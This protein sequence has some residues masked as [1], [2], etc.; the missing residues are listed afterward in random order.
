MKK[1]NLKA[2]GLI[3]VSS[4]LF[5]AGCNLLKD[6][7]YKVD[8]N[9]LEMHG[10]SI[11][12]VINGKFVEKGLHK[13]AVV[14][15]TPTLY[16]ADGSK[17]AFDTKTFKGEKAAGNGEVVTKGGK[18]FTYRSTIPYTPELEVADLKVELLPKKGTKEK[19]LVVTDKIADATIITPLL[20]QKDARVIVGADKF[21]RTTEEEFKAVIHYEKNKSVVRASELKD[22]DIKALED[23]LK[24][25][26]GNQR[27][28]LK[29][30]N[31]L[32]YA[33]P[34]G[35]L[36]LNT[37]LAN[38]RAE[39]AA[40]YLLG[41]MKR[42]KLQQGND[43]IK[44]IP[45]GEDWDGFK[46]EVEKTT[47]PDKDII[48]RVLQMTAD[49]NKRE[50][51]IRAMAKTFEFLEKNVLPQLRRSQII[52]VYD[53]V[54]YSDD[55]LRQLSKTN[56]NELKLEEILYAA[57]LTDDLNE[58]LRMYQVAE[59]N[60]PNDYR[61]AN[62]VGYVLMLQNKMSEAEAQFKKANGIQDNP[63][64]VN[65]LAVIEHMKGNRNKALEMFEASKGAGPDVA[66]NIGVINIQK[67]DYSAA[68]SNM[69]SAKTFNKALATLLNGDADAALRIVDESADKDSA[70]GYYLKAICGARSNKKDVVANNLKSAVAK[71]SSLKEK[72]K[73][74]RE[75]LKFA[76]VVSG[77]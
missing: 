18:S 55:E 71:D 74:D 60:F 69:G 21:K 28:A 29:H 32:A 58:K 56:P 39:S 14:D 4:S 10:D 3:T 12:V 9:P 75:F 42:L 76:D 73:K 30:T 72:A 38:E 13:K 68:V 64:S 22:A 43:F 50:Q 20:V 44:R 36:Q 7:E 52:V 41:A 53:K 70:L 63:V 11:T 35:E 48:L 61:G 45:K 66:Y 26:I 47:H 8:K 77:L 25:S 27:V 23:F 34:E 40:Q 15:V 33:S 49:V 54:G 1:Q 37:N 62:N 17:K 67:G 51:D 6:L 65:N 59:R 24:A 16:A 57:T 2:I 46:V 5:L 19:S 31:I